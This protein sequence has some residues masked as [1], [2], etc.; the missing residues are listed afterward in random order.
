MDLNNTFKLGL[1]GCPVGGHG[2]GNTSKKD[3]NVM[4][5]DA[6]D[7]GVNFIDTADVYGLG[8]SE[9]IIGENLKNF[10][11]DR[12]FLASKFGVKVENKTIYDNSE[13]WF[14]K[15]LHGSLKRLNTDYLDLYQIH[16]WD[17]KVKFEDIFAYFEKAIDQGKIKYMGVTNVERKDLPDELPE[18]LK[19]YSFKFNLLDQENKKNIMPFLEEK[20]MFFLSWGSLCQGLLAGKIKKSTTFSEKDRRNRAE[21]KN[22][23][24]SRFLSN[25][26][27][28]EKLKKIS[29]KMNIPISS[30]SLNWIINSIEN[31]ISLFGAK[32]KLQLEN[33]ISCGTYKI[34]NQYL[35]KINKIFNV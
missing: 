16:Y 29:N 27:K 12:I 23:H 9:L 35:K 24:S 34:E 25:L 2:W 8:Q 19:T 14:W 3:L 15:S 13:E 32:T 4:T 6:L 26:E 11:R 22:F 1:G 10:D 5:Y 30:L 21:Y 7:R 17:E 31:S 28:V 18:F 33:N 20:S